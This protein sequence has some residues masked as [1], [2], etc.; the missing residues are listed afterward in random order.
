MEKRREIKAIKSKFELERGLKASWDPKLCARSPW[1]HQVWPHLC[2]PPHLRPGWPAPGQRLPPVGQIC[3]LLRAWGLRSSSSRTLQALGTWAADRTSRLC[4]WRVPL[5]QRKRQ[6]V[7]GGA[8][9]AKQGMQRG[10]SRMH[11]S[12]VA[13]NPIVPRL[14]SANFWARFLWSIFAQN[15]ID[16]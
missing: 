7:A 8:P 15:L 5:I 14:S 1:R 10:A 13:A 4:C 6:Q 11:R 12:L 2:P 9:T 16:H 3:R